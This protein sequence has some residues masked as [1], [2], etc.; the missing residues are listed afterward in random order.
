MSVTER[1]YQLV[2]VST[3]QELYYKIKGMMIHTERLQ[4]LLHE[5]HSTIEELHK[6][7]NM[8]T[9]EVDRLSS[10]VT[11]LESQIRILDDI[12]QFLS[13][14]WKENDITHT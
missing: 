13:T 9:T 3:E 10:L 2:N 6:E 5:N 14:K 11:N 8:K 1:L 4:Y 7:I 12:I